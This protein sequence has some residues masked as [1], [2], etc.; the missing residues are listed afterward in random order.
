MNKKLVILTC[1]FM[2]LKLI[3]YINWS[4]TLVTFPMWAPIILI[5]IIVAFV[6]LFEEL[7]GDKIS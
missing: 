4:W 2:V 7:K 6:I 3:G 5:S 1:I